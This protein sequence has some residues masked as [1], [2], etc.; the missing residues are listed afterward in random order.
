MAG[1]LHIQEPGPDAG[2]PSWASFLELGFRPLYLVGASWALLSLLLWICLPQSLSG[3]LPGVFW[4]MHEMLWGFVA[5]IAVGFLLTAAAN[6]TGITPLAGRPLGGLLLLW[7]LARVGL[8]WPSSAAFV[9]GAV[10]ELLFF[11]LAAGAVGRCIFKARS[12]RNYGVPVLMLGLGLADAGFLWAVWQGEFSLL[13]ARFYSGLLCMAVI[14]LLIVRRVTPFFAMRAVPGLTIPLHV[15]SGRWQLGAGVVAIVMVMLGW[16]WGAALAL[17]VAGGIALWQLFSWQPRAVRH[18]PLLWI[19]YA[20]YAGLGAGLLLAALAQLQPQMRAAWP[21]HLIAVAGFS[22][23]IIGMITRTALGHLG[24]P[25]RTDNSMVAAYVLMLAAA[26]L[27]LLALLPG[28]ANLVFLHLSA[29]CWIL[30]FALYL[31]RFAPWLL[32]PRADSLPPPGARPPGT[33][34]RL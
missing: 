20:G 19:L 1:L 3:P 5:T 25:L 10:A 34:A 23:L 21:V 11:V 16:S 32:R 9:L 12:R 27:R 30:A 7:L 2:G 26:G 28:A 22:V 15:Q 14:A 17:A 13:L 18:V 33:G 29:L 4:H 24:R 8:L 31:W 6:W